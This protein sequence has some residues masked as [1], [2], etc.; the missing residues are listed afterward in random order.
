DRPGLLRSRLDRAILASGGTAIAAS[1]T[2]PATGRAAVTAPATPAGDP[3]PEGHVTPQVVRAVLLSWRDGVGEARV[4]LEPESLGTLT[5][6]LRVERGAV[7]AT[8]SSEVA[9]VRESIQAHER[10]LRAGLAEH[11]LDLDRLVV[12]DDRPDREGARDQDARTWRA[13]R[14]TERRSG[15][16]FEIEA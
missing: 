6:V 14:R 16:R 15:A 10:D 11:G 4:R 1:T 5:V 2:A 7:T 8:I 13:P 12:T 9:A 3:L